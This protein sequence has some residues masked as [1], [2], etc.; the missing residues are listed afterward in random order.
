MKKSSM[1]KKFRQAVFVDLDFNLF[2]CSL[3]EME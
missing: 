2:G 1:N 3:S